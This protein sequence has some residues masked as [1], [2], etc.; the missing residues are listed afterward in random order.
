VRVARSRWSRLRG[1]ALRREPPGDPLLIP[2]CRSVHTF[3]M[4]FAIDLVW[5]GRGGRVLRVDRGVRPWRVRS[6]RQAVEVLELAAGR[7]DEMMPGVTTEE[8]REQT[9]S[10]PQTSPEEA[11]GRM[12]A[13]FDPR[14]RLYRDPFNEYFV[15]VLS[16]SGAGVIVPVLLYVVMAITGLWAVGVFV[17]AA[18]ALELILIFGIG[19]PQMKPMERVGWGLLWG[20]SAAV[21]ALCF[22]YL[23]ADSTL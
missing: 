17:L 1:L 19:R 20:F 16:A 4:R 2:R 8:P 6:C 22:F 12:R 15:F 7:A 5:L 13:G 18:A 9:P 14:R 21:L 23:V 3:G 11:R 10:V